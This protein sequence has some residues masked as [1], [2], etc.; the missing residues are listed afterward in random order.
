[1]L[2]AVRRLDEAGIPVLSSASS[3]RGGG[4]GERFSQWFRV[5]PSNA[6]QARL[7]VRYARD[8]LAADSAAVIQVAD[9]DYSRDLADH[10]RQ[11]AE[12]DGLPITD[13]HQLTST[14]GAAAS[15]LDAAL[16]VACA[17][18]SDVIYLA[19]R[20]ADMQRLLSGPGLANCEDVELAGA[21][22]LALLPALQPDGR[23]PA[24]AAGR[25]SYT[26]FAPQP[27]PDDPVATSFYQ[28]YEATFPHRAEVSGAHITR[29]SRG[30]PR[31]PCSTYWRTSRPAGSAGN[32]PSC[33]PRTLTQWPRSCGYSMTCGWAEP[34][35]E[36]AVTGVT[37]PVDFGPI[38]CGAN[39]NP[40]TPTTPFPATPS[41]SRSTSCG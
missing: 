25:L 28:R 8:E 10:F 13:V 14:R 40:A 7:A 4:E 29:R 30:M 32:R 9:D 34:P 3:F 22:G 27:S 21:D 31:P 24:A 11:A 39:P 18:G 35:G 41:T 36:P 33:G 16:S 19:G 23:F 15:E 6:E 20:A 17:R 38:W 37:G 12:S 26:A 5:A 1:M 2:A